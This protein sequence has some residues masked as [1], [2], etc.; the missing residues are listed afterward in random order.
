MSDR[1]A[2][3]YFDRMARDPK[4]DGIRED[5]PRLGSWLLLLMEAE[6][7][8]PAPAFRP[9]VSWVSNAHFALF[10]DREIIDVQPDGRY[11][12]HGLDKERGA[13]SERGR[14]GAD[15]R[16]NAGS[17]ASGNAGSTPV[18]ISDG[19]ANAHAPVVSS[20]SRLVSSGVGGVGEGDDGRADL[21]AFLVVRF[22]PPT[23]GQRKV[24]DDYLRVFDVTGPQRAADLIYRNPDDPIGALKADLAAFRADRIA[25]AKAAETPTP[26]PSRPARGLTGINA[27]LAAMLREQDAKRGDAA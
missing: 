20:D 1:Y 5:G 11:R 24:M 8:W 18:G 27:E 16:W 26:R 7:A 15:A 2:R 25:A 9:P 13:R 12:I 22:R 17:N 14:V 3:V 21:E 23:P 4:F 6:K 10:R 19:N